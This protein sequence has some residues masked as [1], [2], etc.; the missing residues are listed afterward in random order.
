MVEA[1]PFAIEAYIEDPGETRFIQSFKSYA[2]SPLFTETR[3]LNRRFTFEDLLSTFL[4]KL[5][6]YAGGA[7]KSG[8]QTGQEVPGP[9]HPLNVTGEAKGNSM[10]GEFTHTNPDGSKETQKWTATKAE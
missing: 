3:V 5:R 6:D 10:T 2:A 7:L 1:G 8:P 9:F 4:L